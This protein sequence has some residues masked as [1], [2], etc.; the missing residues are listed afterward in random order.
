[1]S[2]EEKKA[3]SLQEKINLVLT[4]IVL[5]LLI[6]APPVFCGLLY[7]SRVPDV[8]WGNESGLTYSRIWMHR[9]RGV[10]G[11]AYQSQ[12][13]VAEYSDSEVCAETRLRFFLWSESKKAEPASSTRAMVFA[14]NRWQPNGEECR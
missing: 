12:R 5:V 1:M 4:I 2:K 3:G 8:T 6:I 13:V 10:K 14:N 9:D 7:L 11:I